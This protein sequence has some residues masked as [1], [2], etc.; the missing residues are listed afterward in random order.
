MAIFSSYFY[1]ELTKRYT[2]AFGS[3]FTGLTVMRNKEDG[4]EEHR[5]TVPL[6]YAPKEKFIRRLTEDANHS[7]QTAIT[8]PR[9]AFEMTSLN[10]DPQRKLQKLRKYHYKEAPGVTRT[11]GSVYTPVPY[12]LVFNLY[13][14]TK[15][16]D[17]MLQL[18]EQILPAFTP[19]LTLSIKGIQ[20][21]GTIYD[22]PLTLLDCAPDDSYSGSMEERRQIMW[23]L[24]F[25]MKAIYFGPISE[26]SIIL[27]TGTPLLDWKMLFADIDDVQ[28]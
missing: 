11:H 23:S 22:V 28:P 2:I 3:L 24:S 25:L 16:Q 10:Y 4:T 8:L 14:V 15:T 17:E 26:N 9:I 1:H 18:V 27:D 21:P 6:S 12:D 7:K 13:I 5:I 20:D 19:D